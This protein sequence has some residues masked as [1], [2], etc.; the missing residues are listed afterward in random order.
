LKAFVII[1]LGG[2]GSIPGA[3]LGGYLLG[4][5]ESI[6]GTYLATD[7][8]D[9]IAFL[10]LVIILSIRPNGLFSKGV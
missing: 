9:V 3:I 1:V 8:K 5:A 10:F 6:G 2:M 4:L 7:Y